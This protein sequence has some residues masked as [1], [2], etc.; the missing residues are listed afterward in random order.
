MKDFYNDIFN[1]QFLIDGEVKKNTGS[2]YTPFFQAYEMNKISLYNY[3]LK[4]FLFEINSNSDLDLSSFEY[5][6]KLEK[7]KQYLDYVFE[8]YLSNFNVYELKK[9]IVE[10]ENYF[11]FCKFINK[12]KWLDMSFGNGIFL[13]TYI[14][15]LSHLNLVFSFNME[16]VFSNIYINDIN[17]DAINN[18]IINTK[19]SKFK[20]ILDYINIYNVDSLTDFETDINILK[21]LSTSK[22]DIIIGNP[23]Y[24]GEKGNKK[25]FEKYSKNQKT[26]KYYNGKMDL[27]YFFIYKAIEFLSD[28]GNVTYITTSYFI[29][30]DYALKLRKYLFE[31]IDF[32]NIIY[33]KENKFNDNRVFKGISNLSLLI[34]SFTKKSDLLIK[35][36][37]FDNIGKCRLVVDNKIN[38]V[39]Q[40]ELYNV[41][42]NYN[43]MII[44]IDSI[45]FKIYKNEKKFY[46][47]K[48]LFNINQGIISGA[49]RLSKYKSIKYGLDYADYPIFVYKKSEIN[50]LFGLDYINKLD[51]KFSIFKKFI[52]SSDIF[53]DKIDFSKEFYLLYSIDDKI[54]NHKII[55]DY[56]S[57][58]KSLLSDR[59]EVS[60]GVIKWYNLHWARDEKIF[61][62][63]KVILP[64]RTDE[65]KSFYTKDYLFASA[66]VYFITFNRDKFIT[67]LL[68]EE[69]FVFLKNFFDIDDVILKTILDFNDFSYLNDKKIIS[70]LKKIENKML[71]KL[72]EY[73]KSSFVCE[74][75]SINGKVKGKLF[76]LYATPISNIPLV[77]E[78][79]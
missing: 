6:E 49:D 62:S 68:D 63:P 37:D 28:V 52:K 32:Q 7:Y 31:N 71:F 78:N 74:W 45:F 60:N 67:F 22:F 13:Y 19:N 70:F 44:N 79:L 34:Y 12:I 11:L 36:S 10:N 33:L 72:N 16:K 23:P 8:I 51:K 64:S 59:R 48:D 40:S 69:K 24:L 41:N 26:C 53:N 56:I 4:S 43:I 30:A 21:I 42:N 15:L 9:Q 3:L 25:I 57:R 38:Y 47:L 20:K 35:Y 65:I 66:D 1:F 76:E 39:A 73:L 75:L 50:Q 55:F 58:Y 2:V 14:E 17:L 61:I 77:E 5:K 54:L 29:S 27:F 18:F 46:L